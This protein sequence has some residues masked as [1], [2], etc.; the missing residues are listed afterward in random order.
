VRDVLETLEREGAQPVALAYLAGLDVESDE[1][2]LYAALR[3]A[4]LLLAAGGDPRRELELDGRAVES[5]AADLDDPAGRAALAAGLERLREA[6]AGL[7]AV[8]RSLE[9][10]R[11]DP[12]LA[13]RA[14]AA[15][16]LAEHLAGEE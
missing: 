4:E 6:A 10:L 12:A 7:P 13:W 2:E 5:L 8:E 14:H 3:R 9:A 16:L 1:R 15:A 11:A